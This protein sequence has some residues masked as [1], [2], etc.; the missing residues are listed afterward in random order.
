MERK[1]VYP[2]FVEAKLPAKPFIEMLLNKNPALRTGGS[3]EN[4][5]GHPWLVNINWV[6]EM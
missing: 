4:L 3:I 1:L 2:S 5:K 6:R